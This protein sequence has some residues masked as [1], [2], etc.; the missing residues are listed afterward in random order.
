MIGYAGITRPARGEVR[1]CAR[2]D[3]Q[4]LFYSPAPIL[5]F[6]VPF[7]IPKNAPCNMLVPARASCHL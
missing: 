3:A 6:T 4:I 7:K 1:K 5:A 2:Q